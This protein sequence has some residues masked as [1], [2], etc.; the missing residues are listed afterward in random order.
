MI[1]AACINEVVLHDIAKKRNIFAI[2]L[3]NIF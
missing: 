2:V 3:T 1:F